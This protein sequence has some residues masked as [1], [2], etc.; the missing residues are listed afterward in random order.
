MFTYILIHILFNF[1]IQHILYSSK[2]VKHR[3]YTLYCSFLDPYK[4]E[5]ITEVHIKSRQIVNYIPDYYMKL[6]WNIKTNYSCEVKPVIVAYIMCSLIK[7]EVTIRIY[8]GRGNSMFYKPVVQK[9]DTQ[10]TC[11]IYDEG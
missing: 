8:S 11:T 3:Q 9:W 5:F 6:L 7:S 4:G 2:N 10:F 1:S